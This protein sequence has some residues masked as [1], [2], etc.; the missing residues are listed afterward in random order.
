MKNVPYLFKLYKVTNYFV[1][2]FDDNEIGRSVGSQTCLKCI[3]V[4]H[5]NGLKWHTVYWS[6]YFVMYHVYHTNNT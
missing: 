1:T 2:H 6:K 5:T 4:N 3:L